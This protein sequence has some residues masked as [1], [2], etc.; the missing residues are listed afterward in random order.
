MKTMYGV[1]VLLTFVVGV[2]AAQDAPD[3]VPLND[4][5][6][7]IEGLVPDGWEAAGPGLYARGSAPGD[8][9]V[10][11]IQAAPLTPEALW[12]A[13]SNQ[14]GL[15]AAPESVGELETAAFNWTLYQFDVTVN[16]VDLRFDIALTGDADRTYLVLLQTTAAD[17]DLLHEAVFL[18]VVQA[19][20]PTLQDD[21]PYTEETVT[22]TN[23]DITLEGTLT[24]PE[25]EGQ[26]PA[27]V[28]MTGT[29][30]QNRDELVVQGFPIFRII[31]D[32]LSQRGIAVLRYDDRGVGAS[33]GDYNAASLTDLTSD[34]RAAVA[35]LKT[36]ADI[37]TEQMGVFGHSEGGI[38][39]A[40]I[41]ADN[42]ED[43]AFIILMA[44]PAVDGR[45]LL[46][47]QN[48]QILQVGGASQD[49]I[50]SQIA[51]LQ[52]AFPLIEARDWAG[53]EQ[54][55]YDM[56]IQQWELF[57]EEQRAAL[58]GMSAEEYAQRQAAAFIQG[59]SAEWFVDLLAYDPAQ[60]WMQTTVPVLAIFGG[61]DVQVDAGM[62]A[63]ALQAALD[64]AGNEDVTI[65]TLDDA[66]H[67]FQSAETGGTNEYFTLPPEFTA[68]FLPTISDWLLERVTVDE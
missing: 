38:Y 35:Y 21:L 53:L 62:N 1:F 46:T 52:D 47:R 3:L 23:G 31:A 12:N 18:P 32:H 56:V 54:F 55:T 61:L 49:L 44:P 16:N 8:V 27:V 48:E 51:F 5:G 64:E 57:T 14:L 7:G 50:D 2:V 26:H 4:P 65:V 15:D 36:R 28:M 30:P 19:T 13:L 68:D 66:N 9:T 58:G 29:G 6:F 24:L 59:Y 67:L 41:G 37:N 17:Y 10:L 33:T 43:V 34:A 25:T 60:D 45:T 42:A 22:F 11:G 63:P 40:M 39:A 20:R